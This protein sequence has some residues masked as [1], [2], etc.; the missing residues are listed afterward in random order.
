MESYYL[1]SIIREIAKGIEY[2]IQQNSITQN[3]KLLLYGLDRYSFA[4]RTILSNYGYH[5]VEGYISDNE[6]LVLQSQ[7]EIKNFTCRFL[8]QEEHLI[9]VWRLA[10][11]LSPFDN[12]VTILLATS[13]FE[14]E[15]K[16]LEAMGYKENLH[17]YVVYDFQEKE[18]D[19]FLAMQIPM[20]LAEVKQTEKEILS[21]VD[22]FCWKHHL[23]YWVCGGTL[24]GTIRHQG[25][26]PWDDDIDIFLPWKD[27]QR[28][29][30]SFEET[31]R[32]SMLGFGTAEENDFPDLFAKVVDKRTV[33]H[34]DIGTIRKI[35]PLWIDVFPLVGL[36]E[37]KKERLSFFAGYKELNRQIWQ[38]FYA[39]NGR[40][41][42]FASW[43]HRQ[44]EFLSR[45][46]FDTSSYVGVLGTAYGERDCTTRMVYA[47]TLRRSFE[48][49]E[50]NV[51][52]GYQEY[53]DN[54]YGNDWM[55]LPEESKRKTHHHV[56]AYWKKENI[57][58]KKEEEKA[59]WRI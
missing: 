29:V 44:K 3:K 35:N 19:K 56:T 58:I 20:S 36:P 4:M 21:Y 18:L 14:E 24:L 23:R 27:Y 1:K 55:K 57:Q 30:E 47:R 7:A 46:D 34:E 51:P 52:V 42:I 12:D 50:V 33:I 54:L 13:S 45:Y 6:S 26:I 11:R 16:K 28:L 17:F 15:K 25:F 49:I 31:D 22:M 43:F 41:D 2:L 32:F 39:A 53:L 59:P 9:H 38:D 10:E 37:D 8:N 48:D 5:H 40:V